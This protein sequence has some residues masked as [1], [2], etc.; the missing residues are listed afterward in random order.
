MTDRRAERDRERRERRGAREA[1]ERRL[2][3]LRE[4]WRWRHA[5]GEEGRKK[6][7]SE[8]ERRA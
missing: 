7:R 2:E 5:D 8:R 6:G 1:A 4:A 3:E